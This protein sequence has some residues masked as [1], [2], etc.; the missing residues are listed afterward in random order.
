MSKDKPHHSKAGYRG[1]ELYY[2]VF[3]HGTV[4]SIKNV[5]QFVLVTRDMYTTNSIA[6]DLELSDSNAN[7]FNHDFRH[8]ALVD[9]G[10]DTFG[11][12]EAN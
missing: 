4:M 1:L 2:V 7:I 6:R 10:V 3:I 9:S 8:S 12:P 11:I 5:Y